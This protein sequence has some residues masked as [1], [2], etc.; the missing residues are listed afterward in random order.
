MGWV[1]VDAVK[2]L[3]SPLNQR[4]H[5]FHKKESILSRID[6]SILRGEWGKF[7]SFNEEFID[8]GRKFMLREIIEA[9]SKFHLGEEAVVNYFLK[10]G[11]DVG[12]PFKKGE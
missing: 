12:V 6:G 1:K 11:S 9:E 4:G 10:L 7:L 5:V 3:S 8:V 2:M